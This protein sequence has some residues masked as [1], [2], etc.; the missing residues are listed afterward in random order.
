MIK[1]SRIIKDYKESGAFNAL[2]NLFAFIDDHVF[3]TKSGEVG[4]VLR[5][6]GRDHECLDDVELEAITHRFESAIRSFDEQYRIYQYVIKRDGAQVETS[7]RYEDPVVAQALASRLEYFEQKSGELY[8]IEAY[9]VVLYEGSQYRVGLTRKLQMLVER[10]ALGLRSLFSLQRTV[11][12]I[13]RAIE[14]GR[15][16]LLNKVESFIIHLRDDVPIRLA[17]KHEAFTFFRRLVNY[18]RVKADSVGLTSN[19][20]LDYFVADSHLECERGFLRLD[21]YFVRVLTLKDPPAATRPNLF[22]DLQ[23]VRSQFI[24]VTEFQRVDH[25]AI[26]KEIKKKKRHYQNSMRSILVHLPGILGADERE[27]E[28]ERSVSL[29]DSAL[30]L[31]KELGQCLVE[32]EKNSNYFGTASFTVILYDKDRNQLDKSVAE[33]MKV[34]ATYD[35]TLFQESYNL[36]NAFLA[37]FPGNYRYNLRQVYLLNQ[38]YADLA[39]LYIP[40]SGERWNQHLQAEYLAVLETTHNTPY[41]VNLHTGEV[42]HTLILGMTGAGKSFLLNF[43]IQNMQ[44]YEPRTYI[45]DMGGSYSMLTRQNGGSY[46]RIGARDGFKINPFCLEPTEQNLHFL[47]SFVKTLVE[48][49][50]HTLTGRDYQELTR[51]IAALYRVPNP[52]LRRLFTLRN[53]LPRTVATHLDRWVQGG[54]YARIFDNAEDTLTLAHFQTFD[55]EGLTQYPQIVEPMLFY[56]LHRASAVIYDPGLTTTFKA[57]IID[58]AWRFLNNTTIRDYVMEAEKTWRR[59]NAAMILASQSSDDFTRNGIFQTIVESNG[60]QI[61]LANPGADQATYR[62][63]FKLNHT[64]AEKITRLRMKKEMLVRRPGLSKI[65][66]LNVSR[67]DYWLYTNSAYDNALKECAFERFGLEGG[68]DWLETQRRA[69]D[70]AGSDEQKRWHEAKA[71]RNAA[72]VREQLQRSFGTPGEVVEAAAG[73]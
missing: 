37:T 57:F 22:K 63:L 60:T 66:Q 55:F 3:L 36:L 46:A 7:P 16:A 50:G 70:L 56:V 12:L 20:Y 25:H 14:Q 6:M 40:Q 49:G 42:A 61:F 52:S 67:R 43:L 62:E 21:D 2:L 68:L 51:A 34:F 19:S 23:L 53:I 1:L 26:R 64:E 32:I 13:Q 38:T 35:A 28:R 73:L 4:V 29:D 72:D 54:Q 44:K 8:D 41:Y 45:F 11:L 18:D 69:I 24:A 5:V 30:E 10:P 59:K 71:Q 27:S 9:L 39:F 15:Q 33:T 58:E 65:V 47:F 31:G 48:S 17:D